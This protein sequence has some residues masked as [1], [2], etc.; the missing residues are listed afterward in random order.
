MLGH[1]SV[2]IP[3]KGTNICISDIWYV[4]LSTVTY[5]DEPGFFTTHATILELD[6]EGEDLG[7]DT[8]SVNLDMVDYTV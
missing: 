8:K 2:V 5:Q 4:V 6:A 1:K 3:C 7:N